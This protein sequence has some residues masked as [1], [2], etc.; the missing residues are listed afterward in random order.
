MDAVSIETQEENN[1]IYKLI[2]E[3]DSPY[4]WTSGRLC[5][6]NGELIKN[7]KNKKNLCNFK[8]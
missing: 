8:F 1:L 6:F 5:D 2:Q 4:I 3:N 7:V